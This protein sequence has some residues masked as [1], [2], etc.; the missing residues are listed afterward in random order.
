MRIEIAI[1][2]DS[3][4][5]RV[6]AHNDQ[7]MPEGHGGYRPRLW[8][9]QHDSAV[10]RSMSAT[11]HWAA[12]H[13]LM[14][15]AALL[16][17]D[18][19]HVPTLAAVSAYQAARREA[20]RDEQAAASLKVQQGLLRAQERLGEQVAEVVRRGRTVAEH[21]RLHDDNAT[22]HA[23]LDGDLMFVRRGETQA[24]DPTTEKKD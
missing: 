19:Q 15:T 7:L 4:Q 12:S 22:A 5:R 20:D 1:I 13:L 23:G 3:G 2:D 9:A 21:S 6:V 18:P 11:E 24:D 10:I 8:D 14:H 17:V 16:M